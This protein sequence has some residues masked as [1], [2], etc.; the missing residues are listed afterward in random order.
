MS[1]RLLKIAVIACFS[2]CFVVVGSLFALRAINGSTSADAYEITLEN[3][4]ELETEYACGE[5]V[6]IPSGTI[7]GNTATRIVVVSPSGKAYETKRITLNEAGRYTVVWYANVGGREVSATKTFLALES[8]ISTSGGATWEYRESLEKDPEKSGITVSL[9]PQS[10]FRYNK[11]IDL[12]DLSVPFASL[13]PYHGITNVEEA[14]TKEEY[15]YNEEARNY[16]ITLTDCYDPSNYVTIDLEWAED[17]TY[18][19]FRAGAVGQ[20]A[21]GLRTRND[22]LDTYVVVDGIRYQYYLAPGQGR[23]S[24]N[25][26]DGYGLQLYYDVE[27]NLVYITFCRYANNAY[28]VN[29]RA[30]VADLSNEKIYPNN[31][32][33]GFRTGE[34]YL[35]IEVKNYIA[36]VANIDIASLGGVSGEEIAKVDMRDSKAPIIEVPESLSDDKAVAAIGEEIRVPDAMVYDLSLP[37]G[38]KADVSVYSSYDPSS[39]KN[40]SVG[41]KDGKFTPDKA[42]IYTVVYSAKDSSGNIATATALLK[43][44]EGVDG[45]AVKLTAADRVDA[46]AGNY[47]LI[48]NC[49]VEGLYADANAIKTYLKFEDGEDV[50]CESDEVFLQGVGRYE[51]TFVYDTP[52]KSYT[53]TSEIVA[54]ASDKVDIVAPVLPEYFI[55]GARYTLDDVYA[56]EYKARTPDS[57]IATTYMSSDGGEYVEVDGK[58]VS[59][60]ADTKVRF[61]YE[62]NGTA[63]Y[64]DE[65]KVVNV[66]SSSDDTL[67]IKD[68]FRSEDNALTGTA[69]SDGV[70]FVSDGI[71]KSATLNYVNVLALSSFSF[72]FT[73]LG[74][75]YK[76]PSAVTISLVDYYDR[77]NVSALRFSGNAETLVFSMNGE[78]KATLARAYTDS[79]ITVSY[80]KGI[81][82]A[83]ARYPLN[84]TFA[85]DRIILRVTLEGMDGEAAINVSSLCGRKLSD[86]TSDNAKPVLFLSQTNTGYR[87]HNE[88]I[89]IVRASASDIFAPYL[90]SGLKLTVRKP[91]GAF[92]TSVDGVLLD[93]TCPVDREYQ[94]KLTDFGIYSILFTYEDQNGGYCTYGWSPIIKDETSPVIRVEGVDENKVYGAAFGSYVTVAEYSVSDNVSGADKILSYVSV[95]YPSGIM[96]TIENG[97]KFVTDE[98]GTYTVLYFC[99]DETGNYSTFSYSVKVF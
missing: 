33:K 99:C 69:T 57:V 47:V 36:N 25:K 37:I 74:E 82:L 19:N 21:H 45:K 64:S 97:G 15:K 84:A 83:G 87:P 3:N 70:K 61:K 14:A 16:I 5:L 43:S 89:T 52:F 26:I 7:E 4:E 53:A 2:V 81:T 13:Y 55:K 10:E 92:A 54:A 11:A 66:G 41:L 12:T 28:T 59:V 1:K 18:W 40:V 88:I 86:A 30:L 44:V 91:N 6:S 29:E 68:Y 42:G 95:I 20:T 78:V 51:V 71:A 72:D 50:L 85:S 56:Y 46:E 38:T 27:R 8:V 17:R 76:A 32:F 73:V 35:S 34:V 48:P 98:R 22:N 65:I 31:P 58:D 60:I 90:E 75:G 93:G 62:C 63:V 24:C 49:L 80:N 77:E 96:R 9:E 94:L 79:R 23:T 39:N 67:S